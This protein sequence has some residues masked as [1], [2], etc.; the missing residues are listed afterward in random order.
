MRDFFHGAAEHLVETDYADACPIATAAVPRA[1]L[2]LASLYGAA[3]AA[4]YAVKRGGRGG[5]AVAG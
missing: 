3:D 4:L 2:D 5:V 1:G